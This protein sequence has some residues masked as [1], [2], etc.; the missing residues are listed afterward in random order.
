[1]IKTAVFLSMFLMVMV[2]GYI[3]KDWDNPEHE[4]LLNTDNIIDSQNDFFDYFPSFFSSYD[5]VSYYPQLKTTS[6]YQW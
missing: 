5:F 1:M 6:Y 4:T 2:S 3:I